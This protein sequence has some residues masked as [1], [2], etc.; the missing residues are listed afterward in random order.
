MYQDYWNSPIFNSCLLAFVIRLPT[1]V[2]EH[3]VSDGNSQGKNMRQ[4]F[5]QLNSLAVCGLQNLL[6]SL[7]S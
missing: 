3:K 2:L 5:P 6:T 7:I 1:L 4:D